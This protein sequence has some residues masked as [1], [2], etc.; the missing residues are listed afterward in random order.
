M[1]WLLASQIARADENRAIR[2]GIAS[3]EFAPRLL[4]DGLPVF[5]ERFL[6]VWLVVSPEMIVQ[7][8]PADGA[9]HTLFSILGPK[10][11]DTTIENTSQ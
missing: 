5:L 1:P 7:G 8:F 9:A 11:D 10:H 4:L 2:F 6:L 3:E